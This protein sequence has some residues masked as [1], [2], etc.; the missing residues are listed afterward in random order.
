MHT[1]GIEAFHQRYLLL[2]VL[3]EYDDAAGLIKIR[4]ERMVPAP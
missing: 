1:P 4:S 3:M 2:P